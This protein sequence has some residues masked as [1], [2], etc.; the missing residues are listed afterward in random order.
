[1][2][3]APT[4]E[5]ESCQCGGSVRLLGKCEQQADERGRERDDDLPDGESDGVTAADCVTV[6]YLWSGPVGVVAR[7]DPHL[8]Y[9]YV[10]YLCPLI[11]N[12]TVPYVYK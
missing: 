12:I 1:M 6:A 10:L 7:A 2:Y 9:Q 11:Q 5:V 4:A 3:V 8:S